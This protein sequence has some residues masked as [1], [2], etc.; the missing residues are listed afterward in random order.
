MVTMPEPVPHLRGLLTAHKN[1]DV[2]LSSRV[3]LQAVGV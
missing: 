3:F 2:A 1:E